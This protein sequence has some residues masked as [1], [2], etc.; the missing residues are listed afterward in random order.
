MLFPV[1]LQAF[2]SMIEGEGMKEDCVCSYTYFRSFWSSQ[3]YSSCIA[4]G[5]SAA[6]LGPVAQDL[7]SPLLRP[8]GCHRQRFQ[9]LA[10]ECTHKSLICENILALPLN[11]L[12]LARLHLWSGPLSPPRRPTIQD[13]LRMES[14]LGPST[15]ESNRFKYLVHWLVH[16]LIVLA[17]FRVRPQ[18]PAVS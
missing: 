16:S 12:K 14:I 9:W 7:L 8:G 18:L 10:S 4:C 11:R 13:P 1:L 5:I 3:C 15:P 6:N 2:S 17:H